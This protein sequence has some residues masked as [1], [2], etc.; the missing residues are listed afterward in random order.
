MLQTSEITSFS[1]SE[2]L[3]TLKSFPFLADYNLALYSRPGGIVAQAGP[4]FDCFVPLHATSLCGDS[5]RTGYEESARAAIDSGK[6]SVFRCPAG[7]LCFAVPFRFSGGNSFCLLGGGVRENI[8]DLE[9]LDKMSAASSLD[10]FKL[11]EDM[12]SI[13]AVSMD[14][15]AQTAERA[16]KLLASLHE[17]NLYAFMLEKT[18]TRLE[19]ISAVIRQIGRLDTADDAISLFSETL[20]LLFDFPMIA[21]GLPLSDAKGFCLKGT[22]GLPREL[23]ILSGSH[24]PKFNTTDGA[25]NSVPLD[26]PFRKILGGVKAEKLVLLPLKTD[27]ELH[28]IIAILDCELHPH[29]SMLVD[30]LMAKLAAKLAQLMRDTIQQSEKA[31]NERLIKFISSLSL[32]E[33]NDELHQRILGFAAELLHA[34][35]GSLMLIEEGGEKLQIKAVLGLNEQLAKIISLK[36]GSGIAG[37]VAATGQPLVVVDIEKDRRTAGQNRPRFK[38]KSFISVP[39]TLRGKTIGVLNLSDRRTGAPF[40]ETDLRLLTTFAQQASL[41]IERRH[42]LE[43]A[44]ELEQLSVTDALTGLY[45]R[46]FL[47]KRL[48]EEISRCKRG[49]ASFTVMLID[50]DH[51]KIYND[52]CGHLAGDAALKKTARLLGISARQMDIVT[53]YG[54]EEFCVVLPNAHKKEAMLVAERIRRQIENEPFAYEERLPKGKLTASIG[55]SSFPD[56]GQ[57]LK[58]LIN[59]ADIALYRAKARGRNRT[60]VFEPAMKLPASDFPT[61]HT[62]SLTT[63]YP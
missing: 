37:R 54:G 31:A 20:G 19:A 29:E 51:F 53:R 18:L 2:L 27:R 61:N 42:Y 41:L 39:L 14:Q 15:L 38:S 58:D 57:T 30:L 3:R 49:N 47:E 9:L 48:D 12:E 23:G 59:T 43:R 1:S 52:I 45:N 7:I 32:T 46:R 11:I 8:F 44:S 10:P 17:G 21:V 35:S 60:V 16:G 62:Y 40:T 55:F 50:I 22:W 5:C 6:T 24:L 56:D 28:G 4:I 63:L 34:D 25:I 13:P 26:E 33:N 36:I